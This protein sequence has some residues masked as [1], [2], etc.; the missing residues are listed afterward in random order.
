MLREGLKIINKPIKFM[1]IVQFTVN[2]HNDTLTFNTPIKILKRNSKIKEEDRQG[3]N[4]S[5]HQPS[6]LGDIIANP[7][8]EKM[9]STSSFISNETEIFFRFLNLVRWQPK[10]ANNGGYKFRDPYPFLWNISMSISSREG[11]VLLLEYCYFNDKKYLSKLYGPKTT[12][13]PQ[14]V[15]PLIG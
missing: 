2:I 15:G 14:T 6:W 7:L 10:S 3:E 4:P 8:I 9:F 1:Y 13:Q 11:R 12:Y 5:R